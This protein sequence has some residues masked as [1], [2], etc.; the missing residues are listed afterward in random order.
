MNA[1]DTNVLIYSI[2]EHEPSKRTKARNLIRHLRSIPVQTVLLW[3]V[4]GEFL[5][6]SRSWEDRGELSRSNVLRYIAAFRRRFALAMPSPK[7]LDRSLDLSGRF[8]L[9]HWDSMLIAACLEAGITT[10]YTEDMGS[11]TS[12]DGLQLSNPFV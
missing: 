4:A 3:Q 9:S 1:V 6:Y 8:R 11:P 5:R 2:D 7:V 10:L 12:Y